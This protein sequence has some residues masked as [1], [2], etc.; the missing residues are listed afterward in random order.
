MKTGAARNAT[1]KIIC[2]DF[3]NHHTREFFQRFD[4]LITEHHVLV[5]GEFIAF[6]HLRALDEFSVIDCN[7]LLLHSRAVFLTQQIKG[8][9]FGGDGGGIELHGNGDQPE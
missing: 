1:P 7:V 9:S 5:F 4:F 8:N 6:D 2:H 3:R